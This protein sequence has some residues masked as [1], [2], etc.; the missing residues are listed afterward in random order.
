M[1]IIVP[2]SLASIQLYK[3]PRSEPGLIMT[4]RP[5]HCGDTGDNSG[6]VTDSG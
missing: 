3:I 4:F 2:V 1:A 5:L 6:P